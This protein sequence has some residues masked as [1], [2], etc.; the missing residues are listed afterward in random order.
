MEA[1]GIRGTKGT[2]ETILPKSQLVLVLRF[3]FRVFTRAEARFWGKYIERNIN[4]QF[5]LPG[6]FIAKITNSQKVLKL[7]NTKVV[8][9]WQLSY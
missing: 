2:L 1:Y 7:E 8:K 9:L 4:L 3:M 6:G 5:T